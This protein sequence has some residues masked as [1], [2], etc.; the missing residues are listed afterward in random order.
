MRTSILLVLAALCVA[1]PASAQSDDFR[2][3]RL[4]ADADSNSAAAYQMQGTRDLG[5]GNPRGAAEAFYWAV[6]LDPASADAMYGLY[7]AQLLSQ[8]NR[9]VDYMQGNRRIMRSREIQAIDSLYFRALIIDPFVYRRFQSQLLR[10]YLEVVVRRD[11]PSIDVRDG[12]IQRYVDI[13][14][15][16]GSP[17]VKAELAYGEGRFPDAMRFYNDAIGAARHK[18]RLRAEMARLLAHVGNNSAA[19]EAFTQSVQEMRTRDARELVFVY[20]SK[21][22]MEHSIGMLHERMGNA[23]AAREAYGRAL[24]EDLAFAP[25]HVRLG[26]MALAEGDTAAAIAALDLATETSV[27]QPVALYQYGAVLLS[28]GRIEEAGARFARAVEQ[29]PYY[30]DP[31]FALAVARE[32]GGDAPGALAA[33]RGFL[34]RA[35]QAHPR[36]PVA[37][38]KVQLMEQAGVAAAEGR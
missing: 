5:N 22:L 21:A 24:S 34:E 38:Q 23:E 19:L 27:A 35:A 8:G 18:S 20:E 16:D 29:A 25:A 9:L 36:R 4:S 37:A 11:N 30:A 33:Y 15:R 3:P 14:M 10:R 7:A 32:A 6:Q 2:R 28:A 1:A 31:Y 26:M 13:I 17:W 12:D